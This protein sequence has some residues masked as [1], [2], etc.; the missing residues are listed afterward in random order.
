MAKIEAVWSEDKGVMADQAQGSQV[1]QVLR[2]LTL[3]L[4]IFQ[5]V[6]VF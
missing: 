1:L 2:E 4:D 5:L 6:R 3:R